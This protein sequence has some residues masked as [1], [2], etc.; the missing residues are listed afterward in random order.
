[1]NILI[2]QSR[3]VLLVREPFVK[4]LIKLLNS[5]Q[6]QVFSKEVEKLLVDL[7]N[8]LSALLM[9]Y[10]EHIDLFFYGEPVLK[11]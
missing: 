7:L 2:T 11:R 4:P 9:Q 3:H 10:P 8:Q 1:M 5:C 6:G